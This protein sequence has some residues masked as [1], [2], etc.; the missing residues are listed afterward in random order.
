MRIFRFVPR[1]KIAVYILNLGAVLLS[2]GFLAASSDEGGGGGE[3]VVT[4][5]D[6]KAEIVYSA[7][8]S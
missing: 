8:R 2:A 5:L 4:K 1:M 7:K 3:Y 6:R